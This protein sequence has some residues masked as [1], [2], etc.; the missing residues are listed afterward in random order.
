MCSLFLEGET[1]SKLEAFSANR[2]AL[3]LEHGPFQM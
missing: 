2:V 3:N 1:L